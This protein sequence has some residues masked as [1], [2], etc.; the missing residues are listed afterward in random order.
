MGLFAL[1]AFTVVALG[2]D[3][4]AGTAPAMPW[5][6]L[7]F[8]AGLAALKALLRYGEQFLGHLVA[9]K[10]LELL[11]A[12]I[13]RALIPRSPR[14]MAVSRSGDL[15]S[16]ATKDVDRIEV[17]FAHTFAPLVSAVVVPV[18][19][20]VGFAFKNKDNFKIRVEFTGGQGQVKYQLKK[21]NGTKLGGLTDIATGGEIDLKNHLSAIG[22][23]NGT[24][25]KIILE[26][27]DEA[28][29]FT[30]GTDSAFAKISIMTLFEAIDNKVPAVVVLP[31]Y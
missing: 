4:A 24:P 2:I 7:A 9:F 13:Y 31:F 8:M 6:T 12:E 1:G 20:V 16:R 27:W 25:T 10:S 22:N 29:D 21:G 11:R 17:F 3:L 23:S 5:K 15:L 14:V 30:Q 28:H 19:I 26:L 18:T